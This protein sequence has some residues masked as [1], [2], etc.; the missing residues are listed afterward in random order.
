MIPWG[1]R[2]SDLKFEYLSE[3]LTK[4]ENIFTRFSVAQAG[5][6][7]EKNWRSKIS[8][9]CP[10]KEEEKMESKSRETII[11]NNAKKTYQLNVT[12]EGNGVTSTFL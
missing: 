9:D 5:S 2:F 11:S 10:F 6:N 12:G 8:L 1:V 7:Y 4:I 3:F